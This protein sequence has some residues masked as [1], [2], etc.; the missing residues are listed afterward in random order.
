[1]AFRDERPKRK[2]NNKNEYYNCYKLRHFGRNYFFSNK[3]LNII[4]QQSW[5]KKL[6]KED[7]RKNKNGIYN[8]I[9]N[10]VHQAARNNKI[11][12]QENNSNPKLFTSSS[13]GT[14]FMVKEGL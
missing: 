8:S 9:L 4:T 6:Q 13:I 11:I 3:R 14:I 12:K 5:K 10:K 7:L 1:M 2:A